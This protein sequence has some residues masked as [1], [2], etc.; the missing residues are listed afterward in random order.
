MAVPSVAEFATTTSGQILV[1]GEIKDEDVDLFRLALLTN[2]QQFVVLDSAGGNVNA[3]MRLG[4]LIRS[5]ERKTVVPAWGRCISACALVYIAGETR[6]SFGEIGLHRPYLSGKPQSPQEIEKALSTMLKSLRSYVGEMGITDEFANVMIN[7]PPDK[8]RVFIGDEIESIVPRLDPFF[9]E[10][11]VAENARRYGT[12]TEEY[13]R[14]GAVVEVRCNALLPSD[15][16][17]NNKS[18]DALANYFDCAEAARWDLSVVDYKSRWGAIS[19]LCTLTEQEKADLEELDTELRQ[20]HPTW[21]SFESCRN[22]IMQGAN[23]K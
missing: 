4:R 18:E 19:K 9:D 14:R 22:A 15:L 17:G 21:R 2:H 5:N 12:S 16:D 13:R 7:T 10:R 23:A 20:D 8:V 11:E 6:W 3:A 1:S